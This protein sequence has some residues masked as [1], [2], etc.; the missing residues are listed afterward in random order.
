MNDFRLPTE[1]G[2]TCKYIHKIV[3]VENVDNSRGK[4][5]HD[6]LRGAIS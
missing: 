3:K 5:L 1:I 4:K 6:V 2:S